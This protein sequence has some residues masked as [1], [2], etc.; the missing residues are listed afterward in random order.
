MTEPITFAGIAVLAISNIGIWIDKLKSRG[1]GKADKTLCLDH[2][3]RIG[4]LEAEH[5][6]F[7]NFRKENR[8]DH[9]KIF[10]EIHKRKR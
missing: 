1:N 7:E 2:Q 9:Q 4:G 8:Q 10:D 5:R 6:N 3:K